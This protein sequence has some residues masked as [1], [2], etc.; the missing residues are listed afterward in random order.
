MSE[1]KA[2]KTPKK[3]PVALISQKTGDWWQDDR[4]Y[5]CAYCGRRMRQRKGP[6]PASTG[7]T[8]DHVI[9]RAHKGGFVTIPCCREC[10]NQKGHLSLPEF[11]VTDYFAATRIIRSPRQWS[12][13]DLW[14][15]VAMEAVR[16][17]KSHSKSWPEAEPTGAGGRK[18]V[19][20]PKRNSR[21]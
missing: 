12:L 2:E 19:V 8:H 16:Q 18:P 20:L 4:R 10:N 1:A 7:A 5:W 9:P 13:R 14:L 6:T 11:L 15:A 21:S 3:D 17:A